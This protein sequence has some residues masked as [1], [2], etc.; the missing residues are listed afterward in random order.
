MSLRQ[1]LK[2]NKTVRGR[3]WTLRTDKQGLV[4]EVKMI[5]KPE[6]YEQ[7]KSARTMYGDRE[8]LKILEENYEKKKNNS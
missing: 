7:L 5:F 8:L 4:T 6:E 2:R 1:T 3:R